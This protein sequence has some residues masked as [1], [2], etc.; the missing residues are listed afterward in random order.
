MSNVEYLR[1][2]T[3]AKA[4]K[5]GV[6]PRFYTK[7]EQDHL[8]SNN[9]GRPIYR[10]VE[11]VEMLLPG[12]MLSRPH[13]K[14]SDVERERWPE[15]YAK[16]KA[17][18]EQSVEGTPIEEWP[19]LNRSMVLELKALGFST[20]EQV[21]VMNDQAIQRIGMGG[22][23][24]KEKAAAFLDDATR[25]AALEQAIAEREKS[26]ARI[27]GLESQVKELGAMVESLHSQLKAR[28][29]APNPLLSTPAYHHDPLAAPAPAAIAEPAQPSAL[30]TLAA[31]KKRGR[32][33]KNTVAA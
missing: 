28:Q 8:A 5:D 18:Q 22:R 29:D 4:D 1:S 9:A 13:V 26:E 15:A 33:A 23:A 31:P 21:S 3:G 2:F 27:H 24:L 12:N 6:V 25:I 32:P 14:V 19:I 17:G 11:M 16:F 7:A 30:D 20:V 10:D